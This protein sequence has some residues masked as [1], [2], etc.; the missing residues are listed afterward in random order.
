M[1]TPDRIL[2]PL[3]IGGLLIGGL[4]IAG[5]ASA[6]SVDEALLDLQHRWAEINYQLPEDQQAEAFEALAESAD[7]L[8]AMH[9]DDA[10]LLTW[11]GIIHSTWAGA[12]GGLGALKLVKRARR[13][14][15]QAL[16]LDETVLDGSA[17]TSLGVLFHQVP[18][19][20]VGFGNED[21]A[22]QHLERGLELSPDGIDSNYFFARWL[23]DQDRADEARP[24]LQR[25]MTA[26]PRPNRPLADQGRR[27]EAQAA[28]ERIAADHG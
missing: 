18:G 7:A 17:H 24:Y 25:A 20:P 1:R 4:T 2:I 13:Y 12:R 28:L 11:Q 3:L 9:P 16:A 23:I 15:E 22:R 8:I 19:W 6:Q 21:Q 26:A 27:N 10:R 5:T 14:F